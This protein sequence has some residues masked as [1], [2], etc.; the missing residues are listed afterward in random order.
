MTLK[1]AAQQKLFQLKAAHVRIDW[2]K[3][4]SSGPAA[5][6]GAAIKKKWEVSLRM[7][8]FNCMPVSYSLHYLQLKRLVGWIASMR[9]GVEGELERV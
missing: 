5:G 3:S 9:R 7:S 2:D 8:I 4:Y 1:S 6:G